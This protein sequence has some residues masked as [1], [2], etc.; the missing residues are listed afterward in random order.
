[1]DYIKGKE[2]ILKGVH[3]NETWT[4]NVKYA[5]EII[6]QKWIFDHINRFDP[7]IIYLTATF[8]S[9]HY[10]QGKIYTFSLKKGFELEEVKE[11]GTR[12]EVKSQSDLV[13]GEKY[14]VISIAKNSVWNFGDP[15]R[16]FTSVIQ[17][18]KSGDP[19][20][21]SCIYFDI[22]EG[23]ELSKDR[24]IY[25]R[26]L[27]VE[28]VEEDEK[29]TYEK[30]KVGDKFIITQL[31]DVDGY[32]GPEYEVAGNEFQ[33][34]S[35]DKHFAKCV[36]TQGPCPDIFDNEDDGGLD[37]IYLFYWG[38]SAKTKSVD[39]SLDFDPTFK[40]PY[41]NIIGNMS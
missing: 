33:L 40:S 15:H 8:T 6:G 14:R 18:K 12:I 10:D 22:T 13:V 21:A 9:E 4:Q 28:K 31:I 17:I 41:E 2:Y 25:W 39:S 23:P 5:N 34:V 24:N 16:L 11:M 29:I 36:R 3:K 27:V 38:F 1:M 7:T 35:D 37:H 19:S 30:A 26:D 32:A 20:D